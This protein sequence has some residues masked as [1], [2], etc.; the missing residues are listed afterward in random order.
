MSTR[1]LCQGDSITDAERN[2]SD[3]S[4]L[5]EGYPLLVAARLGRDQPGRYQVLN[6]GISGNRV[7]DL[8]ARWQA[9][10]LDL[11]PE[12]V[13][14]LIGVNDVWHEFSAHNGVAAPEYERVYAKLLDDTRRALPETRIMVLEPF[15]VPGPATWEHWDEFHSEVAL[16]AEAAR[17]V[18]AS[19]DA[20][21][22]PLQARFEQAA[23][24]A[25][26]EHWLYDGVH[27]TLAGHQLIADAWLEAFQQ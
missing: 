25:P 7:V 1:I 11:A 22:I 14:I 24:Q 8:A 26:A 9:D 15:V 21:Y 10:C 17:R 16:R 2:R 20:Q 3:D 4:S 19:V 27:P 18:A 6:R 12:I 13:G 5:G 23:E